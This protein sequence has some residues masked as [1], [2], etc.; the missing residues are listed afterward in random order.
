MIGVE[1]EDTAAGERSR[2][3]YVDQSG[4][5]KNEER[6]H[7]TEKYYEDGNG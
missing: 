3:E 1:L 2:I 6:G 4:N 7:S 5:N